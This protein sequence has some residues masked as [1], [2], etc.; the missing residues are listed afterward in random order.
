MEVI[1]IYVNWYYNQGTAPTDAR[2]KII[3]KYIYLCHLNFESQHL[4]INIFIE[5]M[6]LKHMVT[7]SL[8]YTKN[9]TN[10]NLCL[11]YIQIYLQITDLNLTIKLCSLNNYLRN[12]VHCQCFKIT[13]IFIHF[14]E[15]YVN[16][17]IQI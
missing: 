13:Q 9:Q 17:C 5:K 6:I 10:I 16:R 3:P 11:S 1:Y 4:L 15:H 7:L 12:V 8:C 14:E 2:S